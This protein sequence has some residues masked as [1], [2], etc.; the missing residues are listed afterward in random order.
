MHKNSDNQ[1]QDY[2]NWYINK[3]CWESD[4]LYEKSTFRFIF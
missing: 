1:I 3:N 2:I 4:I